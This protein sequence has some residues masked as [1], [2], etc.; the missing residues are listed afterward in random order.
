[1][2]LMIA[3]LIIFGAANVSA[4]FNIKIP[5]IN[6]PK[7]EQPKTDEPKTNDG[8][9]SS[10]RDT[11]ANQNSGLKSKDSV[12]FMAKPQPTN[13]PVLLKDSINIKVYTGNNYLENSE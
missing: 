10:E 4:Q 12:G 2:F 9:S 7:V 5:K 8:N 6:K 3:F 1:M 11:N 13:V